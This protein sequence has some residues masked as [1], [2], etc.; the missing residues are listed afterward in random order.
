[1]EPWDAKN[2]EGAHLHARSMVVACSTAVTALLISSAVFAASSENRII[3][4]DGD[5]SQFCL[6]LEEVS[7]LLETYSQAI[8]DS[9]S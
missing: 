9:D 3:C 7:K 2:R 6:F 1:M 5:V 8:L 4:R